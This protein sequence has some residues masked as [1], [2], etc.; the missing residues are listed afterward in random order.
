MLKRKA[1]DYAD[2]ARV[3]AGG[4]SRHA[5]EFAH[6]PLWA[7]CDIRRILRTANLTATGTPTTRNTQ[8]KTMIATS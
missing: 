3:L 5:S 7:V 8:A 2:F 4:S 6:F 1:M